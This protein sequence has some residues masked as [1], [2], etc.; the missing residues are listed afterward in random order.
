M[1]IIWGIVILAVI[2]LFHE[3]GH[4]IIAKLNGIDVKEFTIGFG[5]KLIG[6]ERGGTTYCIRMLPFGGACVFDDYDYDSSD[7]DEDADVS[8]AEIIS[9]SKYRQANVWARIATTVA[10][11]FFNFLLA[12][13]IGLF[14]MNYISMP[15]S[16]ITFVDE[17]SAA[18]EAGLQV[19]DRITKINGSRIYLYPEV[20]M[21]VQLGYGKPLDLT[22]ERAG[23]KTSVSLVPKMNEEYGTYMIG[24]GFGGQ[25][26]V[27]SSP[28]AII[29]NSYLYVRYM[30]K[31]TFSGLKMFFVG[32]AG[33]KD[34]AGPVGAVEI[35]SEEYDAAKEVG[36]G[37]AI[38]VSMLNI[39]LLLSANL[40]VMNLLPIPALDGGKLVFLLIEAVR[41]KPADA[42]AEGV[43]TFIGVAFLVILMIAVMYNDIARLFM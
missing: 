27:T 8:I 39:A 19:G 15:S 43:I 34:L 10:G 30:V 32:Q 14:L 12:F 31:M 42:K 36:G 41:G 37:I 26:E 20:S 21:A 22:Y 38:V 5:P 33:V 35:V 9:N 25:E 18:E 3:F 1:K 13:L 4:F 24:V 6:F 16:T 17:G 29:K 7:D 40:G 11:P 2:V 28:L 23:K